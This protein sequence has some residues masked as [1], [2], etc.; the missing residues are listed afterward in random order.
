MK[1]SNF[2]L[3]YKVVFGNTL[4]KES[5][6]R[7]SDFLNLTAAISAFKAMEIQ[8]DGPKRPDLSLSKLRR[9]F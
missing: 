1:T 5:Y 9:Q 8:F 2:I 7:C 3:T 6:L 4:F